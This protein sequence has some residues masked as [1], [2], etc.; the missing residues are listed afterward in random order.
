MSTAEILE[1]TPESDTLAGLLEKQRSAFQRQPHPS[2]EDRVNALD[3]LHNALIDYKD[4]LVSAV[5]S[6]FGT[7][8]ESET[9]MAEIFPLLDGIAYCRKNLRRWMKP[10]KTPSWSCSCVSVPTP[11]RLYYSSAMTG[12][13][14]RTLAEPW[15]SK[16]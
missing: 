8:S 7:R 9:L 2:F 1:I 10:Q 13:S 5:S 14:S 15:S 16:S 3:R 4:Q 12:R 11:R 6:D